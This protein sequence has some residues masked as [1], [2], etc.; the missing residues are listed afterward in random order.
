MVQ[1]ILLKD[2]HLNG[3]SV[4]KKAVMVIIMGAALLT[5]SSCGQAKDSEDAQ[6]NE[7]SS[8]AEPGGST[9]EVQKTRDDNIAGSDLE[10]LENLTGEY[11]YLSD[12][13]TG[14]LMIQKSS[15]GYDISDYESESSCRFLADL[16]N[17]ET[18][19]N[20]RIYIKYPEPVFSADK[21]IFSYYVL[22]YNSY[23]VSK[24]ALE[25]KKNDN[26]TYQIQIDFSGSGIF[27]IVRGKL[28]KK[29]WSLQLQVL[30]E[31]K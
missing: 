25:I 28:R 29:D 31:M 12:Y 30:V 9:G 6:T 4:M 3:K 14:K 8:T 24:P 26:E 5:L 1:R 10:E 21:V 23:D 11:E 16:S 19:E 20:N 17:I 13:G 22:E 18:I 2:W 7:M 15:N 27:M